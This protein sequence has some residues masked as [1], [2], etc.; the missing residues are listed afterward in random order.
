MGVKIIKRK[1]VAKS[2][3]GIVIFRNHDLE[4]HEEA[5]VF[6][7]SSFGFDVEALA[8]SNIPKSNNPDLLMLGTTWEMKGPR[9]AN[10]ETIRTKFRKA[11]RQSGGRAV[12]DLRNSGSDAKEIKKYIIDLFIEIH[13]MRRIMIIEDDEEMLDIFK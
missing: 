1:K 7:L 10:K 4:L 3:Y 13:E 9:K 6:C 5:T 12:F 8:P 2:K 11:R